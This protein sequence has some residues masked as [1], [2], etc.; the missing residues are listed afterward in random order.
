MQLALTEG[1]DSTAPQVP[2]SVYQL[3]VFHPLMGG[4]MEVNV[5]GQE[6]KFSNTVNITG[7]LKEL[8]IEGDSGI[9][10]GV[11]QQV[12]ARE[13]WSSHNLSQGDSV[14]IIRPVQGG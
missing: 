3:P 12:I 10:V 11:N 14:T 1:K 7:L 5:N 2:A 4:Y 9:A 13:Q 8:E 6:H